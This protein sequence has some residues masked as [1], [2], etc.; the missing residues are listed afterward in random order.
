MSDVVVAPCSPTRSEPGASAMNVEVDLHETQVAEPAGK[1]EKDD[2]TKDMLSLCADDAASKE[3]SGSDMR[4]K[5][6]ANRLA[7]D[8]EPNIDERS[9]CGDFPFLAW[10]DDKLGSKDAES[11]G[12]VRTEMGR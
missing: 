7:S 5:R 6:L 1:M 2:V 8:S 12:D 11:V 10:E 4:E 3:A 9:V